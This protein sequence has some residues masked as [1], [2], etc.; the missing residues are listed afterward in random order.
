VDPHVTSS[1]KNVN[2]YHNTDAGV[3]FSFPSSLII[4]NDTE[5]KTWGTLF[6]RLENEDIYPY[7]IGISLRDGERFNSEQEKY[8]HD[9]TYYNWQSVYEHFRNTVLQTWE[10][11]SDHE[12]IRNTNGNSFLKRL[13]FNPEF[14]TYSLSYLTYRDGIEYDTS[15][16]FSAD[17]VADAIFCSPTTSAKIWQDIDKKS[18]PKNILIGV[19]LLDDIVMS[20]VLK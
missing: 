20:M 17:W 16:T 6:V 7:T 18:V 5:N 15:F 13:Y 2:V 9:I 8:E 1:T 3:T 14:E 11:L 19:N 12:E 4:T 10:P